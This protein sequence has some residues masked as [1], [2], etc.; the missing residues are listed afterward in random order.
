MVRGPWQR[1][2]SVKM[3]EL[4]QR[5]ASR[6]DKRCAAFPEVGKLRCRSYNDNFA[7]T[8]SK[9]YT[10]ISSRQRKYV[11]REGGCPG[12]PRMRQFRSRSPRFASTCIY[13]S[14]KHHKGNT[15]PEFLLFYRMGYG[16][17]LCLPS[18]RRCKGVRNDVTLRVHGGVIV[19][20][21]YLSLTLAT[22]K[23]ENVQ[24]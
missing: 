17:L 9:V 4:F 16:H 13:L 7:Q 19:I 5:Y 18:Q 1:N 14:G 22:C 15:F 2:P 20:C 24:N 6:Q 11:R 23:I 3:F 8:R 10:G 12:A 21:V